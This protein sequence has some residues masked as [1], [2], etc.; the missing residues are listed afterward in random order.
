MPPPETPPR[1]APRR[2]ATPEPVG[3]AF[4]SVLA[5]AAAEITVEMKPQVLYG[6]LSDK[7]RISGKGFKGTRP[8]VRGGAT[9]RRAPGAYP[10]ARRKRRRRIR[11]ELGDK[12]VLEFLPKM[13]PETYELTVVSDEVISLALKRAPG[14]YRRPGGPRGDAFLF[15]RAG[16]GP[17]TWPVPA[18]PD[19]G[20]QTIYLLSLKKQGSTAR[21]AA[22]IPFPPPQPLVL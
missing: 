19:S 6:E 20:S 15:R 7:L 13:G 9:A 18:D 11:A 17:K 8:R 2:P 10:R 21:S 14:A 4:L 5:A 3:L 1:D 12:P 22:S 16:S